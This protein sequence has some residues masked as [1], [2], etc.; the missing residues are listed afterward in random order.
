MMSIFR[1]LNDTVFSM[2]ELLIN[3]YHFLPFFYKYFVN[4]FYTDCKLKS[5][6]LFTALKE[7]KNMDSESR[8]A[9]IHF[10]K[11]LLVENN[12]SILILF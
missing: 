4:I 6:K 3:I 1:Q 10:F 9:L 7:L 11:T 8:N 12:N 5:T 2:V